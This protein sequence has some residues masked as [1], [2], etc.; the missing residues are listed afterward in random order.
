MSTVRREPQF[1]DASLLD[2]FPESFIAIDRD[3]RVI[4]AN[5]AVLERL[6]RKREEILGK[7]VWE[8]APLARDTEFYSQYQKVLSDGVAAHF[9]VVYPGN[10]QWYEVH[11]F[12]IPEG[13]CA[14]IRDVTKRKAIEQALLESEERYR[15]L[16]ETIQ[17]FVWTTDASGNFNYYNQHWLTYTGLSLEQTVQGAWHDLIHLHDRGQILER[18]A[19]AREQNEPFEGECRLRRASDGQYRWHLFR[20][21]PVFGANGEVLRRVGLGVD[22]DDRKRAEEARGRMSAI[23]ESSDDAII[24]QTLEGII[25]TWNGGAQRIFGYRA[26]EVVGKHITVLTAPDRQDEAVAILGRIRHGERVE[27]YETIRQT[28]DGR[29]IDVSLTVSPIRDDH[30]AIIGISKTARDV[31]ERKRAEARL[32][33]L[34]EELKQFA[35]AAS[36][37][38][39]EPLRN[40]I[41]FSQ[42]IAKKNEGRE[43]A[44]IDVLI[45]TVIDSATRMQVLVKDLLTYALAVDD[46]PPE[47]FVDSQAV[48]KLAIESLKAAVQESSAEITVD[49]LPTIAVYDSHILQLFQNLIGNALKYRAPDRPPR[50]QVRAEERKSEWI[51][52]VQ[53]NGIGIPAEHRERIFR[54]FKRLHGSEIPGTGIGLAVCKRIVE[55]YGGRIWVESMANGSRFCFTLPATAVRKPAQ[56][57]EMVVK[58]NC[59]D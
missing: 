27:H 26:E 35:F 45:K 37:D 2:Q 55:H 53:D 5:A 48:A 1:S 52:S 30:G 33:E 7:N 28:K 18:W 36:H 11:A 3:F 59:A 39:Q 19:A 46:K 15:F 38:I 13:L 23:V 17:E 10:Q 44:E 58:S 9:E 25:T 41:T 24:G 20:S 21:Q 31:T 4:F 49:T 42:L 50:I 22:I 32:L 6:G 8:L 34:N 40:I 56:T 12:P 43:E 54:A 14:H 47:M 29:L 51:F 16:A 57:S